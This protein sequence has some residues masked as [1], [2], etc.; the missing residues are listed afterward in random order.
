MKLPASDVT[1]GEFP[2]S[3]AR[4]SVRTTKSKIWRPPQHK[5]VAKILKLFLGEDPNQEGCGKARKK[6]MVG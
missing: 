1:L 5:M 3:D 6:V 4:A 2:L